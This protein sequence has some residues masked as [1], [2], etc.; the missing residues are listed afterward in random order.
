MGL[1]VTWASIQDRVA[2]RSKELASYG[3]EWPSMEAVENGIRARL[4]EDGGFIESAYQRY[5][6]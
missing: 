5:M 4:A 1:C 2:E 6:M 3:S